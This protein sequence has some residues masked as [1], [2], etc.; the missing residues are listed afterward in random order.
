MKNKNLINSFKYAGVGI[1]TAIKSERNI[2]IHIF[3][4]ILVSLMGFILKI[5]KIEWLICL[6]CFGLVIGMELVN[7]AL[8]KVVDI[9]SPNKCLLAKEAKDVAAGAVLF[10]ALIAAM[11]GLI[12]FLPKVLL[13]IKQI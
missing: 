12:I 6:L 8:E 5:S 1:I 4:V 2:K 10:V 11:I 3:F 13:F 7:T 9:A